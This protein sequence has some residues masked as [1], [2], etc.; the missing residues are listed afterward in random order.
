MAETKA[1]R[2]GYRK[3]L[4]TRLEEGV[5]QLMKTWKAEAKRPGPRGEVS[6]RSLELLHGGLEV[7]ARSLARIERATQPPA[8]TAKPAVTHHAAR[9]GHPKAEGTAS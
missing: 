9:H 1:A 6:Y 3:E 5:E 8:R 4:S 7:T 2:K